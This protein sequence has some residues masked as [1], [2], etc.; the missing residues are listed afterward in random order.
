MFRIIH[1]PT[2]EYVYGTDTKIIESCNKD[3]LLKN[4]IIGCSI[5]SLMKHVYKV[6]FK[7]CYV[8]YRVNYDT[9]ETPVPKYLFDV[10]EVDDV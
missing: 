3:Y 7:E 8:A 1:L 10:V 9:Y 2:A 6:G 5:Y 4:I